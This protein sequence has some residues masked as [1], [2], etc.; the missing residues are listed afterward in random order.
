GAAPSQDGWT[1][2]MQQARTTQ[3]QRGGGTAPGVGLEKAVVSHD[4]GAVTVTSCVRKSSVVQAPTSTSWVADVPAEVAC[5]EADQWRVA[6]APW[7]G[8]AAP[9]G[10]PS[11]PGPDVSS[12]GGERRAAK[13]PRRG[14]IST[15]IKSEGRNA[16]ST[17]GSAS[18]IT[19][20]T[21]AVAA[22]KTTER[23]AE[24]GK[25]KN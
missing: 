17:R 25:Q 8:R 6:P 22:R 19:R 13:P 4:G 3:R 18:L 5:T 9:G 23:K 15:R 12:G 14:P 16:D 10:P 7:S 24:G 11:L 20:A 2:V 21:A 1:T